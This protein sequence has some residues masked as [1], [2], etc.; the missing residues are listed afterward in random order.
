MGLDHNV[1]PYGSNQNTKKFPLLLARQAEMLIII[2]MTTAP[3]KMMPKN[4]QRTSMIFF[5]DSLI[6]AT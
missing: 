5:K 2:V 1:D 6:G 3:K 4:R